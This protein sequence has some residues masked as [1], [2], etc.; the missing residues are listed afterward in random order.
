MTGRLYPK[1]SSW[2]A[3]T[4]PPLIP[5]GDALY[6]QRRVLLADAF[7]AALPCALMRLL[8]ALLSQAPL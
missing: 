6:D 5:V 3:W 4:A 8:S 1:G 7:A 2:H